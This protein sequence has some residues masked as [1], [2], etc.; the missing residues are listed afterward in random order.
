MSGQNR[1]RDLF[2]VLALLALGSVPDGMV[3]PALKALTVDRFDIAIERA[4]WFTLVPTLGALAFAFVLPKLTR[5]FSPLSMLRAASVIEAAFLLSIELPI[6]YPAVI[7][8]RFLSGACDLAGIAA[9]LRIA[10]RVAASAEGESHRGRS[11][12]AMG[13]SIMLGL[14]I[15]V[16]IGAVLSVPL[17]LPVAAAALVVLAL[18][19][20]LVERSAPS[21]HD[22]DPQTIADDVP[23]PVVRREQ[24]TASLMFACD[25]GLSAVL[26]LV[27]PLAFGGA[28][29]SSKR[30]VGTV[31][32]LSMLGMVLGGP[33]GGHLVDRF[34]A[35]RMRVIGSVLF[36]L[37]TLGIVLAAPLG[38]AVMIVMATITG[39]AAAPLFA[40]ALAIGTQHRGATG[41]FGAIQAAGQ[42]GY[43]LGGASLLLAKPASLG[44]PETLAASA[45]VYVALNVGMA[46]VLRGRITGAAHRAQ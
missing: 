8:L 21:V 29:P 44:A 19:T 31:L 26:S 38:G 46:Y 14:L 17:I 28:D 16:G 5:R 9:T 12:G 15:G 13:T 24:I 40:S 22:A 35:L 37:G 30:L 43:A 45:I 7:F 25:R 36:G 6:P 1:R 10:A 2:L 11:M 4:S 33:F 34:G 18:A 20:Y 39:L 32:G 23:A 3:Y 42:A 27:V 41:V